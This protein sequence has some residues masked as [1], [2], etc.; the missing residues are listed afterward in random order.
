MSPRV[1]L[2]FAVLSLESPSLVLGA[3]FSLMKL[4]YLL[5]GSR[6]ERWD[7]VE[8]FAR[9]EKPAMSRDDEEERRLH[10]LTK[11]AVEVTRHRDIVTRHRDDDY[12]EHRTFEDNGAC[13]VAD[14]M[15]P[16]CNQTCFNL[17]YCTALNGRRIED[18]YY[19]TLPF[20]Q[21]SCDNF[22]DRASRLDIWGDYHT[23]KPFR[24]TE[25]C[26]QLVGFP[27]F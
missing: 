10:M 18:K 3:S 20:I 26:R 15:P 8:A 22:D 7:P 12:S 11:R 25:E 24:D 4:P 23:N 21:G 9:L 5:F 16:C 1:S 13:G 19:P 6:P 27:L 2:I 14:D 17:N